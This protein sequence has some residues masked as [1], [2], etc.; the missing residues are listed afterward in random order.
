MYQG[1]MPLWHSAGFLNA[2]FS[3]MPFWHSAS[4]SASRHYGIVQ[5][6]PTLC[7]NGIAT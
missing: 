1:T 2:G 4:K 7:H 6:F 5:D 3:C